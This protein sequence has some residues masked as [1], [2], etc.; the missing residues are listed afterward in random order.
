MTPREPRIYP[1]P[2][3]RHAAERWRAIQQLNAGKPE[4][5]IHSVDAADAA[6]PHLRGFLDGQEFDGLRDADD[7]FASVLEAF[8]DGEYIWFA[9]EALRKVTLAPA[10]VLLDELIRPAIITLKDGRELAVQLPLVYPESNKADSVF[11]MGIE[12]DH[13]CPDNGPT[14]C[15]GGKMLLVGDE[16]E[17][18]LA[19]CR[20]IEMR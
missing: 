7:R 1:D 14:R 11:A 5:A 4:D 2:A 12:T 20:M 9:W 10:E 3:P 13:V 18:R 8:Q 6:S 16:A 19:E 15:I 17:V